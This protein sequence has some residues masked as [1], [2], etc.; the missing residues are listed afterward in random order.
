MVKLKM[1]IF[2]MINELHHSFTVE[3]AKDDKQNSLHTKGYSRPLSIFQMLGA[4]KY[5]QMGL[6]RIFVMITLQ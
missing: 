1:N 2:T 5:S 3:F 4:S 6:K